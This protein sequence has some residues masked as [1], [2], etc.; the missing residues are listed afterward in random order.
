MAP[1]KGFTLVEL[2]VVIAII[3]LLMA[4]LMPALERA[5]EQGQRAV[6]LAHLRQLMLAYGFYSDDNEG[7]LVN[8]DT[9]EYDYMYAPG[10]PPEDSHY[11]E[12]AWVRRDWPRGGEPDPTVTEKEQ[13]VKDGALYPYAKVMKLYSCPTLLAGNVRTYALAD[14][15]NCKGWDNYRVMLKNITEIRRPNIRI[16]FLD[17]GGTAG[18][19]LGGWTLFSIH[20][21]RRWEWWDPPPIRHGDGTTFAFVDL[22]I[23]FWKWEDQRT[24]DFGREMRAWSPPQP[25][26]Q[27]L[28]KSEVGVWGQ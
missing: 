18:A 5:R 9:E 8:G 22:H 24:I 1:R 10:R 12:V 25:D 15:M 3:A 6:C 27:D 17:D 14:S 7:K 16:T 28:Y 13:A 2:L 26:N 20:N 23:E 11:N 19:A 4:L 21:T